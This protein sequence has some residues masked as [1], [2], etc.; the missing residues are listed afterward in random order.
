MLN[1]LFINSSSVTGSPIRLNNNQYLR[2]R[3][4]LNTTDINI[5]R[6]NSLDQIEFSSI[7]YVNSLGRVALLSDI[8]DYSGQIA[9]LQL[10]VGNLETDV[11]TLEG[12]VSTLQGQ[13]VVIQLDISN[14]E[15]S[16]NF[17]QSD[18]HILEASVTGI[19]SD[20][21]AIEASVLALQLLQG[22][23][24]LLN[25]TRPMTGA[26][27]MATHKIS[28]VVDPTLPQDAATKAYVDANLA[29]LA[30]LTLR[31]AALEASVSTLQTDVG[32]L[33]TDVSSLQADVY[34]LQVN[35]NSLQIDV[36]VLQTSVGSLQSSVGVLQSDVGALQTDVGTLQTDVSN[37]QLSVSF[38]QAE[39]DGIQSDIDY[40]YTVLGESNTA[41]NVGAGAGLFKQK[42]GTDLQFKSIVAGTNITITSNT[43][44]I[45]ID[46]I[47][48]GDI[49][50]ASNIGAGVGLFAAK[51]LDDLQFKSIVAG[52]GITITPALDSITIE[53]TGGGGGVSVY[54]AFDALILADA[55]SLKI[56]GNLLALTTLVP[57][58]VEIYGNEP[59]IPFATGSNIGSGA[60]VYASA[61]SNVLSFRTLTGQNG[62]SIIQ[63]GNDILISGSGAD[64]TTASNLGT[65][66][67][68]FAAKVIDDLQ[69]KSIVAGT[70]IVITPGADS[71]TISSTGGGGGGGVVYYLNGGTLEEIIGGDQFS[72]MSTT[73]AP[74]SPDV[75]FTRTGDGLICSF[76]TDIGFP[77]VTVIPAGT[78]TFEIYASISNNVSSSPGF[79]IQIYKY[80]GVSLT[81]FASTVTE[82]L[83]QTSIDLYSVTLALPETPILAS[84]RIAIQIFADG[85]NTRDITIHTQGNTPSSVISTFTTGINSLN[86]LIANEQ[87][88]YTGISGIDF[89]IASA[90]TDHVFNIPSASASARGLLTSTDWSAFDSKEANTASNVGGGAGV[91][92][93]KTG[94]D[95][96]FKTLVAGTNVTITPGT[97]DVTISAGGGA[98]VIYFKEVINYV[99]ATTNYTLFATPLNYSVTACTYAGVILIEGVDYTISGDDFV[100]ITSSSVMTMIDGSDIYLQYTY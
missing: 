11:N 75:D 31:V 68:L 7:P 17:L 54:D 93:Q 94:V 76:I 63:S 47:G 62:V 52:T 2:S 20:I 71:L 29:D 82:V 18:V 46:S 58:Q 26:L 80:D 69:F 81:L 56:T 89:N 73:G 53:A 1:G 100:A 85:V 27:N 50:S 9:A 48:A 96:E 25:G 51:V 90:G 36:G 35:V 60:S 95:F 49:S 39:I 84:D 77:G 5:L 91:F 13:V 57:G 83:T 28:N 37:L 21:V 32:S 98:G 88:L 67:G 64:A 45:T 70:N 34:S 92:K 22:T 55:T 24:L 74:L 72:Q 15:N 44:T 78:V 4:F 65:G 16:I 86:G 59:V 97:D 23:Y 6:V 10:A 79:F 8:T 43:D 99:S 19:Q 42:V 41:S 14:I 3:N 12:Q 30:A 61:S 87:F 66:E 38:M 40:I 33:Q